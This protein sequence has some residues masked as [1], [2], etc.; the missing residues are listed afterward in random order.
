MNRLLRDIGLLV[1]LVFCVACSN[2]IDLYADY[3]EVPIV[4]G[5]LDTNADTNF[6]KITRAFYV[7]GDAY[8]VAAN[9]DSSNYPGKLDVRLVE[10]RNGDSIREIVLDT[11]TLRNKEQGIFY[12][13]LQKLYYTAEPLGLNSSGSNY[14]YRLKIALPERTLTTR[15]KLVG[16]STFGIQSMGVNFSK[17]YFG[18]RRPFLFHPATNATIYDISM[19]FTFT[20]QRSPDADSV[21]RSFSWKVG[22]FNEDYFSNHTDGDCYVFRYRPESFYDA[23]KEYIG[24]DTCIEGLKRYIGDYPIEVNIA[25]GGENLRQ[26]IY[27]ND[28]SYGF[29]PGDNEFTLIEGGYGVFSSRMT[30]SQKVRLAGETVPELVADRKWGFKFIGGKQGVLGTNR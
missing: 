26:Y 5:M 17:E 23:L 12:A 24:G 8:Q 18:L 22:S 6:V 21:N 27:N 19:T 11:V 25:A 10:Y 1:G 7:E 14:S 15:A 9:P 28:V 3:K 13:P 16:N 20:E 29:F 2:D 4:Y 30:V